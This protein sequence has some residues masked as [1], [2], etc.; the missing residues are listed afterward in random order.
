MTTR[1][2]LDQIRFARG[3]TTKL[4][5]A[6]PRADWGR[7]PPAGVSH[8]AWQVGHLAMAGYRMALNRVRGRQPGDDLLISEDILTRFGRDSVP[9]P[10]PVTEAA[11]EE[12]F[13][14]Y[15]RVHER[16]QQE[17]AGLAETELEQPMLKPHSI[18]RTKGDCLLWCAQHEM[19]H[20]GQVGLLRRQLGHRPLW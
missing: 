11:A 15:Q 1:E 17:I 20:A 12:L 16:I 13:Q 14:T 4:L 6:T 8:I 2:L 19:M 7:V 10:A 9:D 3:Y 5:N 18:C